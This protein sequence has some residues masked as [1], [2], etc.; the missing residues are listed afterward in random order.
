MFSEKVHVMNHPLVAHKLTILRDKNTSVK[1]FRE[2][3]S[4]IG[5]LITYEATR[6]LPLTTKVVETP[7]CKAELPTLA[8]KKFAVVPILRAGLGM[9]E[10][11]LHLIP[12][13]RV[14]HVGVYRD[15]ET[16]RPVEYYFKLPPDAAAMRVF[17][18]DP[19]LAT[20]G[21]I[22]HA[23]GLLKAKGIRQITVVSVIAAPEGLAALQ[24]A[25]PDVKVY[26][27]MLDER[28]NDQGYI[29][30]GLGDCGDRLFGTL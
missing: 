17:L 21:S 9:V 15:E 4:E 8:G 11:I 25:H 13:A 12:S 26:T 28:L 16:L 29:L 3:V 7:L 20:G 10:G 27:A 19:M 23:V 2:L 6:D 14:G 1:D 24:A 30:P 5:M 18:L 22:A